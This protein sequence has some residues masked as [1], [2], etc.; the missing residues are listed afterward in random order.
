MTGGASAEVRASG[1][2]GW[3]GV[4]VSVGKG[5]GR[6]RRERERER[7]RARGSGRSR[8]ESGDLLLLGHATAQRATKA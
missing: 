8:V 2:R 4:R 7:E 6:A 1:P 5:G 3:V